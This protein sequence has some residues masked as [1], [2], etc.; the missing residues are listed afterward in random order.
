MTQ[1]ATPFAGSFALSKTFIDANLAGMSPDQAR[2]SAGDGGSTAQWVLGHLVYWRSQVVGM[3]GGTP[4]WGEGEHEEFRGV[5]RADL[6]GAPGRTFS[7]LQSDLA[8]V[9]RRLDAAFEGAEP[10]GD[11]IGTLQFLAAHEAY[12]AGQLGVFRRLAGLPGAI[13]K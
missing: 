7:E 11:L 10:S 13:G 8:Q 1:V 2:L 3:L 9:T 5:E 12:H 4:L 6:S